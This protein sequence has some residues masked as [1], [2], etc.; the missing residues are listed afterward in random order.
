[1]VT[2]YGLND[3]IGNITYYDSTNQEYGFT[4][5]Y[6]EDTAKLIDDEITKIIEKQY[7]RAID[8][9]ENNKEKLTILAEQLLKKEVIFQDDLEKIFGKR[10]HEI[11]LTEEEI[12]NKDKEES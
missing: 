11:T 1:M 6:S 5:P 4:K 10:P 7:K 8:I 3:K 9:L 2:I 12:N